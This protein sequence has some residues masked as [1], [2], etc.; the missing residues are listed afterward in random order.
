M[1]SCA[2]PA[3]LL[4]LMHDSP[5]HSWL[6]SGNITLTMPGYGQVWLETSSW[7]PVQS[8]CRFL[9][10]NVLTT[11]GENRSSSSSTRLH[12]PTYLKWT[13]HNVGD[14]PG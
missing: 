6:L 7:H 3:V 14:T 2:T 8:R 12:L 13:I 10:W 1:T 4:L 11:A 9:A 5:G